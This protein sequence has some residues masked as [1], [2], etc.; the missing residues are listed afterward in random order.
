MAITNPITQADVDNLNN[1]SLIAIYNSV[2]IGI[3][4]TG[5]HKVTLELDTFEV[6]GSQGGSTPLSTGLSGG[7]INV[8]L[9]LQGFHKHKM[10][11]VLEAV[12]SQISGGTATSATDGDLGSMEIITKPRIL[13]QQALVLY[14]ITV[15]LDGTVFEDDTANTRAILIPK[16]TCIN[17]FELVFQTDDVSKFELEFRGHA[18]VANG[19]RLAIMDDGIANA[20][21]HSLV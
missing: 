21:T 19:F 5:E 20:G 4:Q 15:S 7:M 14:P 17:G 1:N 16:A 12:Y 6:T 10:K 9:A 13:P 11:T 18:D 2:P 8:T 3:L